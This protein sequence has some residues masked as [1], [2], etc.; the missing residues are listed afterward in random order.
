VNTSPQ[1]LFGKA[2]YE[3]YFN[4][5]E[6]EVSLHNNYGPPEP[7]S[8]KAYFKD[9]SDFSNLEI[10]SMHQCYGKVLDIGSGTGSHSLYLAREGIEV[11]SIDIS[12]Y[13]VE[14]MKKRGVEKSIL[15]DIY[16]YDGPKYNTLFL[17]MNGIGIAGKLRYLPLLFSKFSDLLLPGGQVLFDSSDITYL[18]HDSPIPIDRYYGELSFQFECNGI[19]GS[20]FDWLY[21]DPDK[22][23]FLSGKYGWHTQVIY[24]DNNDSYLARLVKK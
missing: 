22:L 11:H 19:K 20:W 23:T 18:Y 5:F 13:C 4:G 3:Y 21:L 1:D 7:Y 16:D 12:G 14:I 17:M 9:E 15:G 24:E 10:F 2:L 8:I 6:S